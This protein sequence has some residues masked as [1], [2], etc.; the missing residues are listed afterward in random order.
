M[1][2]ILNNSVTLAVLMELKKA[3]YMLQKGDKAPDFSLSDQDGNKVSL[4]DFKGKKL[5]IYFYPKANTPG[6]TAESCSL[7]DSY[8][9]FIEK[10][11][12]IIGVSADSISAQK[13]FS[14]KYNFPF[15][16]LADIEK[17]M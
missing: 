5:I 3:Y 8:S 15:P 16:L 2:V 10:G 7:R 14:E 13:V 9:E 4:S 12:A 1:R 6:C 11:Y 17:N